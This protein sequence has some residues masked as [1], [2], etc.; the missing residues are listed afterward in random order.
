[1][2]TIRPSLGQIN[3][4][5]MAVLSWGFDCIGR[6]I[7]HAR[8]DSAGAEVYCCGSPASSG[9]KCRGF[10]SQLDRRSV[11]LFAKSPDNPKI[12]TPKGDQGNREF[13][14]VSWVLRVSRV[15]ESNTLRGEGAGGKAPL[16]VNGP[17]MFRGCD[18]FN[19]KFQLQG[20]SFDALDCAGNAFI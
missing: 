19:V 13:E 7:D 18:G 8:C 5:P 12:K 14:L 20:K 4:S 1:M 2:E 10:L 16:K 3:A 6:D 15:G 17:D 9:K 11:A